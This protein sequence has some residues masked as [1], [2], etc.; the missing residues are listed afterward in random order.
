[1]TS[2]DLI[3]KYI[4]IKAADTTIRLQSDF[5][6]VDNRLNANI[7]STALSADGA[8]QLTKK[9]ILFLTFT[10][11]TIL[12]TQ[13]T[14]IRSTQSILFFLSSCC[15]FSSKVGFELSLRNLRVWNALPR[16]LLLE[17]L[18]FPESL[19]EKSYR[20]LKSTR[21]WFRFEHAEKLNFPS[22]KFSFSSLPTFK[23]N[24]RKWNKCMILYI[25]WYKAYLQGLVLIFFFIFHLLVWVRR[26]LNRKFDSYF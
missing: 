4:Y 2:P 9:F 23:R 25:Y 20:I 12:T 22:W 24:I 11:L 19:E 7:S 5:T 16:P 13:P 18:K 1:M 26:T 17:F 3:S 6:A 8:V 14:H 21:D 15:Y 10:K